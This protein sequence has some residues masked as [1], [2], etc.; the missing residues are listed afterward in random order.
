MCV[1]ELLDSDTEGDIES[2]ISI[3]IESGYLHRDSLPNIEEYFEN[4][5]PQYTDYDFK[6]H[7][8]IT[9]RSYEALVF[10]LDPFL[11]DKQHHGGKEVIPPEK[12]ILIFIWYLSNQ[13]SI[14]EIAQLFNVSTSTA[15]GIIA[16][17]ASAS[18]NLRSKVIR[19]PDAAAQNETKQT[20]A[21]QCNIQSKSKYVINISLHMHISCS[22]II[23][24]SN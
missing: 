24:F 4:V 21:E 3:L 11:C 2:D 19:W 8:R 14:R 23:M 10:Q 22:L 16:R 13:D 1:N 5:V 7:F 9:R 12:Q 18:S 20:F 15:H 6:K 17:V